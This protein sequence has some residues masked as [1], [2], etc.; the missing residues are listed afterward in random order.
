MRGGDSKNVINHWFK[1][2]SQIS[3]LYTIR[4]FRLKVDHKPSTFWLVVHIFLIEIVPVKFY[5]QKKKLMLFFFLIE[6]FGYVTLQDKISKKRKSSSIVRPLD[7]IE[8][9]YMLLN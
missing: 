2:T 9:Q 3:A 4:F 5:F 7:T 8:V 1:S 6:T